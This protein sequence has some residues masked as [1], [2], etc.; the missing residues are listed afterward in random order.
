MGRRKQRDIEEA[1]AERPPSNGYDAEK[2][3]N[4][5]AR[6]ESLHADIASEMGTALSRC[7]DIHADIKIVYDEAKDAAGIPKKALKKVV[8]AREL[9]RKAAQ[10]REDL[11][12]DAQDSYDLIRHALGDLADT[13]LGEAVTRDFK[14][15]DVSDPPF[16][17]PQ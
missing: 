11:E 16:A 15:P 10:C 14:P 4:F 8:K 6:I 1:I 9:E 2:V 3:K 13:P 17:A 7:K 5:I 12:G